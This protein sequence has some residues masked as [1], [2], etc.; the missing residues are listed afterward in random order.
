M[1]NIVN[2]ALHK[3]Y[4]WAFGKN[5]PEVQQ[6]SDIYDIP[7]LLKQKYEIDQKIYSKILSTQREI[8]IV[9]EKYAL[10]LED[11]LRYKNCL[12]SLD[13]WMADLLPQNTSMIKLDAWVDEVQWMRE[14]IQ[15]TLAGQDI[16]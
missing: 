7:I 11:I 1:R 12:K 8:I 6:D 4:L 10:A 2:T 3:I 16:D 14:D 5:T 15:K 13:K 9:N